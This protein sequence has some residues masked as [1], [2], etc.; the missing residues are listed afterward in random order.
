ML[1][2]P[3]PPRHLE[4]EVADGVVTVR[5]H[6]RSYYEK[7]LACQAVRSVASTLAVQDLV[8]VLDG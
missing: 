6:V 3:T 1:R 7:R 2:L 8:E 4:V 5:G